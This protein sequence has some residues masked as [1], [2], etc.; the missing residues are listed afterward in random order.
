[1]PH[2]IR[3]AGLSRA[4]SVARCANSGLCA[5]CF[6]HA[7]ASRTVDGR[8]SWTADVAGCRRHVLPSTSIVVVLAP[9]SAY[10]NDN[11]RGGQHDKGLV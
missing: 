1:L 4:V 7:S 11:E 3:V 6:V 2:G 9:R 10:N 5:Q 8:T